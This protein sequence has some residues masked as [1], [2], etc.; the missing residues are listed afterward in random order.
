MVMKTIA[1]LH[2]CFYLLTSIPLRLTMNLF[3]I[4]QIF[5]IVFLHSCLAN[6]FNP[7]YFKPSPMHQGSWIMM[8]KGELWPKPKLQVKKNAFLMSQLP[9]LKYKVEIHTCS[10]YELN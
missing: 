4:L 8:T 7:H 10:P 1:V 2:K 3:A 5:K 6:Q 9:N